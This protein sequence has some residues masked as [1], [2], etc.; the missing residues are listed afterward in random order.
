MIESSILVFLYIYLKLGLF[1]CS[2][3][4]VTF[5]TEGTYARAHAMDNVVMA[6]NSG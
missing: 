5:F 4:R 6:I 3:V 2:K 1:E